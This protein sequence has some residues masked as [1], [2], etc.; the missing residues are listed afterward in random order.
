MNLNDF[1]VVYR[2]KRKFYFIFLGAIVLILLLTVLFAIGEHIL[3]NETAPV[4]L[5]PILTGF[6]YLCACIFLLAMA[7]GPGSILVLLGHIINQTVLCLKK[8]QKWAEIFFSL[9]G[10]VILIATTFFCIFTF[11]HYTGILDQ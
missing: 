10:L 5:L 9:I 6:R 11:H 2:N 3:E 4:F 8:K 7:G 1:S